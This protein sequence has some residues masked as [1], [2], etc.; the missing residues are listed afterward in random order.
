M[1]GALASPLSGRGVLRIA[2]EEARSFLQNLVTNNVEQV[3]PGH[4]VY[5]ALLSPQGKFLFD[6]FMCA[7]PAE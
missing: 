5:A 4:A 7:D 1:A 3:A 2:G 6:F